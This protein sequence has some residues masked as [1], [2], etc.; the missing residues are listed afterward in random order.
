MQKAVF[1]SSA[2]VLRYEGAVVGVNAVVA[3]RLHSQRLTRRW[4]TAPA[5]LR[6]A[7][8]AMR[9]PRRSGGGPY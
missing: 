3:Y 4:L 7:C 9:P 2:A 1:L 6:T 8:E 5:R